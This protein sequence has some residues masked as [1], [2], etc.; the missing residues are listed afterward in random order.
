MHHT[1]RPTYFIEHSAA[2]LE[3]DTQMLDAIVPREASPLIRFKS[4]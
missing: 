2:Q 3:L 1:L 4:D